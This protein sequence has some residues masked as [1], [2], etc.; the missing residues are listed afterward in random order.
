MKVKI[1]D[2]T[3]STLNLLSF[4][5]EIEDLIQTIGTDIDWI[6]PE[7]D[8]VQYVEKRFNDDKKYECKFCEKSYTSKR[9]FIRHTDIH[10]GRF[11]CHVC[12]LKCTSKSTL[13][14]HLLVHKRREGITVDVEDVTKSKNHVFCSLCKRYIRKSFLEFHLKRSHIN[15]ERLQNL[16]KLLKLIEHERTLQEK[17]FKCHICHKHYA[18]YSSLKTHRNLHSS[19][20]MCKICDKTL[21]SAV[22]LRRH[23]RTHSIDSEKDDLRYDENY[24]FCDVCEKYVNKYR[25]RHHER[26]VHNKQFPMCH[27]CLKSFQTK[28]VSIYNLHGNF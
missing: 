12:S 3:S 20:F 21:T 28:A 24:V 18:N 26:T 10:L 1:A 6:D 2:E 5:S 17:N 22:A 25:L 11:V 8:I 16:N 13:H 9:S 23:F 19:R 14:L 7:L 4:D 27:Y 15:E